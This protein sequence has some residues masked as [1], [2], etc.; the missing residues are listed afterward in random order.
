M[1]AVTDDGGTSLSRGLPH[2]APRPAEYI[3]PREQLS[4]EGKSIMADLRTINDPENPF[5]IEFNPSLPDRN[6]DS[7][8]QQSIDHPI[9]L[10]IKPPAPDQ[11][12]VVLTE[13]N[14]CYKI[15]SGNLLPNSEG[16]G[17]I[18]DFIKIILSAKMRDLSAEIKW[19]KVRFS[20]DKL[21][22][23]FDVE[24]ITGDSDLPSQ[25][26]NSSIEFTEQKYLDALLP[27]TK[28]HEAVKK[29]LPATPPA[30]S[31]PQL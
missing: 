5:F 6:L 4:R 30:D 11:F 9:M 13:K 10:F 3:S 14:G 25:A 31:Q 21:T 1:D 15:T 29:R 16:H 2:E 19:G 27:V 18:E 24:Q 26:I 22:G 17:R 12:H 7:S 23:L 8:L 28:A 20:C